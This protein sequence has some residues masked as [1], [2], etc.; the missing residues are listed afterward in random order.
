MSPCL[1]VD[2]EGKPAHKP[3]GANGCAV[4]VSAVVTLHD[5]AGN[6]KPGG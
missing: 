3:T 1:G 2:D 5:T 4:C 6:E